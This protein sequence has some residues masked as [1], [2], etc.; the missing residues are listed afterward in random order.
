MS[1]GADR[2]RIVLVG[3]GTGIGKTHVGVALVGA[4]AAAGMEVAGL[5]P[6]ES[7]VGS[8]ISDAERLAGAS[9]FHVKPPP[10]Y[11]LAAP[12]SPHLAA[13]LEGRMIELAPILRWVD[14]VEAPWVVVE[15][16]GAL[17]SPLAPGLTNLDLAVALRPTAL[18]LVA[19]DR[20]GVLHDVTAALLALRVLAPGMPD[21]VVVLSAPEETDA[22]TG[23]NGVELMALRIARRVATFGRGGAEQEATGDVAS[24]VL[25]MVSE[26]LG[27]P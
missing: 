27:P 11:M 10:P 16:A 5:K 8:G 26:D 18:V 25:R 12:L 24:E 6:V 13:P 17:L 7:G 19:P 20:L 9:S 2:R 23:T 15:T 3:T 14:S 22:S 4:L 1:V 21:P